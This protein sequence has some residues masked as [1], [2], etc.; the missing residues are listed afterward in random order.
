MQIDRTIPNNKLGIIISYNEKNDVCVHNA[1]TSGDRN[2]MK[3]DAKMILQY[4]DHTIQ[5]VWNVKTKVTPEIIGAIGSISK[6][7]RQYLSNIRGKHEIKD[8]QR[9]VI[10][11]TAHPLR[12]ELK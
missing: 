2:M 11:G 4:K 3:K 12:R 7:S 8:L 5:L 10:F 6:S 9:E 1:A